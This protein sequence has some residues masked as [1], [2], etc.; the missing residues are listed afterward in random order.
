[1][2]DDNTS[3][4]FLIVFLHLLNW[5]PMELAWKPYRLQKHAVIPE[6]QHRQD[7]CCEFTIGRW[8]PIYYYFSKTQDRNYGATHAGPPTKKVPASFPSHDL[9]SALRSLFQHVRRA[10]RGR[11]PHGESCSDGDGEG[12]E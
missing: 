6:K 2:L 11:F 9:V 12:A 4:G 3:L 1:M 7:S 10:R 8:N 5:S